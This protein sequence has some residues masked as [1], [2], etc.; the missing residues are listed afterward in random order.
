MALTYL[1][2]EYHLMKGEDACVLDWLLSA[3]HNF[4]AQLEV[5]RLPYEV[6]R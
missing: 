4:K 6:L 1:N 2:K 3:P 5:P